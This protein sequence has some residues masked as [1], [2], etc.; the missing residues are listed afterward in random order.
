ME[1]GMEVR[2]EGSS[3][4]MAAP[5]T[6]MARG[7]GRHGCSPSSFSDWGE[8]EKLLHAGETFPLCSDDLG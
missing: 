5:R 4:P 6:R 2:W 3:S 1:P 8:D 7:L